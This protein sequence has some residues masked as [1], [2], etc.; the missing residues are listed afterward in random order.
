MA[1]GAWS[2]EMLTYISVGIRLVGSLRPD[3][4]SRRV[5]KNAS[6]LV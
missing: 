4:G 1:L 3:E 2:H 5:P 6:A